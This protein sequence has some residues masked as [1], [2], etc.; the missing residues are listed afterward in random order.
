MGSRRH[1]P[2]LSLHLRAQVRHALRQVNPVGADLSCE[3]IVGADQQEKAL[4]AGQAQ[5]SPRHQ[6]SLRRPKGPIDQGLTP[7]K[8]C[9]QGLNIWRSPGICEDQ[10]PR[11]GL[12][13]PP[14]PP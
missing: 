4:S 8:A 2:S 14:P 12:S 9:G 13:T 5:Q 7:P 10:L 6:F 11:Q 1:Q 3:S